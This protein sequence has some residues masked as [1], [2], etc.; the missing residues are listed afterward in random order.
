MQVIYTA[1]SFSG[2][3]KGGE[4]E[5]RSERELANQLRSDGFILTSFKEI[6]EENSENNKVKI[7]DK[8]L[9]VPLKEKVVFARN[10]SVMISSGLSL[11]RAV[12]DIIL[13]TKNKRLKTILENVLQNLQMGTNFADSLAKYPAVFNELFVNM[14]RVG[15]TSGDLEGV[16]DLLATHLEKENKIINR[17]KGAM[18]YPAVIFLVMIAVGVIMLTYVMPTLL[19][20]FKDMDITLPLSTRIVIWISDI[21]KEHT[22]LVGA[23]LLGIIVFFFLFSKTKV[24]KT[25]ISFFAVKTPFVK[26]IVIK[27]NCAR[28][29]RT[30]SALLRSGV[31][32]VETL[33]II[34]RILS[35]YYY[36]R[37]LVDA[38][39]QI[40]KGVSLSKVVAAHSE[41]FPVIVS[42]MAEV[43]EETGKT[44][45]VMMK[46]AEFYEDE[47]EQ[48][49]KNLSSIIEPVLMVIMG[50]A[51]AFFA[52]AMF[53]P[54]YSLM[55]NIK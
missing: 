34:S 24:G 12:K 26:N 5:V 23:S 18:I 32:V 45:A 25:V 36:K 22:V 40:K 16:L 20:V 37:A 1:K 7:L 8:F 48:V 17:V 49:T 29:A 41:I 15:E 10:L 31:S 54:M 33:K 51:V 19:N 47:I 6:K 21:L 14:V 46:L 55:G 2:E 53:Q 11:P 35:N 28:F 4:L 3:T 42:Q 52:V 30:Y 44:E 50:I 43:G 38:M 39:N 9:T 27:V 13:Q